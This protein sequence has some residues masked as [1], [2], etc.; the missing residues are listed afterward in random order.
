[1][2]TNHSISPARPD[3]QPG[4]VAQTLARA[5][6]DDPALSWIIPDPA[7]RRKVLPR[8]FAVMA[9]QSHRHGEVLASPQGEAAALWYPPGHIRDDLLDSIRDNLRMVGVFGTS[10]P[11]GLK[12]ADAMY[13]RHPDPQNCTY[14]R[15]VGVTPDAQGKGWGGA[16]IRAG[17]ARAAESGTGVLLETATPANVAIYTRLGFEISEE[18]NV[19]DG[20][21]KFWTMIRPA[22]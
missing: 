13:A 8:F 15:Y 6:Q 22:D 12:V 19:P 21:P 7:R 4:R 17:I 10:L 16:I 18:W 1:M 11:R 3:D 20:G 5:F 2:N 14:L 9:E